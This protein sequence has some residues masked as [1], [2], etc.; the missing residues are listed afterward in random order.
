MSR[1]VSLTA[2]YRCSRFGNHSFRNRPPP[3]LAG[4]AHVV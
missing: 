1:I 2:F 3:P 4:L